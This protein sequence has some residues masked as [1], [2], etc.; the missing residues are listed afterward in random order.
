MQLVDR[1]SGQGVRSRGLRLMGFALVR[2]VDV[3]RA[4]RIHFH[5]RRRNLVLVLFAAKESVPLYIQVREILVARV[6][7]GEWAP[8]DIVPSE[9]RLA[10]ELNVSQGT[11]RKAVTDLV[12]KNVLVRRQGKGTFVAIHDGDRALFHFFNIVKNNGDKALPECKTLSCRRK[13]ATRRQVE[14]LHL[15]KSAQVVQIERVRYLDAHPTI[16]EKI[17]LPASLFGGL[18]K[19]R[20]RDLPNTLYEMYENQ[21]G[22]TIHR[23]EERLRAVG[24]AGREASLLGVEPGTPLLEVERTALTLNGTPIELRTSRCNTLQHHYHN[25]VL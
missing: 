15:S 9:M 16:V 23:A 5:K 1:V 21:Y 2:A 6:T 20:A 22:I 11:V 8:G 25:T 18:D 3:M 14:E 7:G 13:R 24:A 19:P 17:I 10:R 4:S 12:E